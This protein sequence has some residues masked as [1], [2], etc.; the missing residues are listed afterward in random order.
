MIGPKKNDEAAMRAF[1][2][3]MDECLGD[4]LDAFAHLS[5]DRVR[6]CVVEGMGR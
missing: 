1:C 6:A 5:P 4:A 3:D 2:S